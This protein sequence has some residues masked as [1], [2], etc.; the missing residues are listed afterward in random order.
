MTSGSL[1]YVIYG[2]PTNVS[3]MTC[4]AST[5]QR[6]GGPISC[7][8][9]VSG[10]S[11]ATTAVLADFTAAST[12]AA[13]IALTAVNGGSAFTFT[14][15]PIFNTPAFSITSKASGVSLTNGTVSYTVY[16][17]PT[18]ASS[19]G[20]VTASPLRAGSIINCTVTL[21]GLTGSPSS[22]SATTGLASDISVSTSLNASV[23]PVT[24]NG[25][26]TFT[27]STSPPTN[28]LGFLIAVKAG[29][30][31][32]AG[33]ALS[34]TVLGNPTSNSSLSCIAGT[35]A[36]FGSPITCTITV[37]NAHGPTTALATDFSA[38]S[39]AMDTI[40][41]T[42]AS[43]GG[44][45]TFTTTPYTDT[46]SFGINVTTGTTLIANGVFS[47][48]V[49]GTPTTASTLECQAASPQRVG[50]A[51]NCTITVYDDDTAVTGIAS[52]FLV[53]AT[54]AASIAPVSTD[55]GST[56]VFSV[57]PFAATTAY[58]VTAT[59]NGRVISDGAP[60]F[61]VFG[62]PTTASTLSCVTA[63]PQ[64]AT[65]PIN[66]TIAVSGASGATNALA[67]DFDVSSSVASSDIALDTS[68][69][70]NTFTFLVT[71]PKFNF[72]FVIIAAIGGVSIVPGPFVTA[73]YGHPDNSSYV[74]CNASEARA[75]GPAIACEI[76]AQQDE[77]PTT[78][79][80]TDFSIFFLSNS[81]SQVSLMSE[82]GGTTFQFDVPPPDYFQDDFYI[83]ILLADGN[84]STNFPVY[85]PWAGPPS[86][87]YSS[88]SCLQS[89]AH[90]NA[91]LT[92]FA[93]FMASLGVFTSVVETDLVVTDSGAS[94]RRGIASPVTSDG[95]DTYAFT[96]D[97]PSEP[98]TNFSISAFVRGE[99]VA[100]SV[101]P[102]YG[103]ATTN[104][105]FACTAPDSPAGHVRVNSTVECILAV[106]G[107]TGPTTALATDFIVTADSSSLAP[108]MLTTSD[109]GSTFTLTLVTPISNAPVFTVQMY[110]ASSGAELSG[111][112]NSFTLICLRSSFD[113]TLPHLL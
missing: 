105:T 98:S 21:S 1:S 2:N 75:L 58:T 77:E 19:L 52:D 25:G 32:I 67:S 73:V 37:L 101:V 39:T 26:A 46:T 81:S 24:N 86:P 38:A 11:G 60:T 96:V 108:S 65:D 112:D 71:P 92:C 53:S 61:L 111:I 74:V 4:V 6:V 95:G 14:T 27:F 100:S 16:G 70:G 85:A 69:G 103:I 12:A 43:N 28:Q 29:G 9:S 34:L 107:A 79:L 84:F 31:T 40:P 57:T 51:I 44:V 99:L 54:N 10:A 68:D 49:Y 87:T 83:V 102:V 82:D 94:R 66:C 93:S 22:L 15:T 3:T 13:S 30:V 91:P 20:C 5:P 55:G 109:G 45:F 18:T 104:S 90:I 42:Q 8:I 106:Q 50:S 48:I 47:T 23:V 72:N 36:R 97:L 113:V 35:P 80:A 63:A 7:T 78:A 41:L 88:V 33:G 110:L 89:Q 59:V 56:F 62:I 64:R 76:Y 17:N